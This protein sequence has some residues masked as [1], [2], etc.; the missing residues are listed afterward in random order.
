M[1][2][3][4]IECTLHGKRTQMIHGKCVLCLEK[5]NDILKELLFDK[6]QEHCQD[7]MTVCGNRECTHRR[8]FISGLGA[9]LCKQDNCVKIKEALAPTEDKEEVCEWKE[10][11]YFSWIAGCSDGEAYNS[12]PVN[13]K[14]H[15]CGKKIKEYDEKE[16]S[17]N[18]KHRGV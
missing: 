1:K 8:K 17:N 3:E 10:G 16:S 7:D 6:I 15:R 4:I 14:C 18:Y 13:N 9:C 5:E 2:D 12:K 11:T